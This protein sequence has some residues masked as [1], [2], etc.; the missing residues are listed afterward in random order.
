MQPVKVLVVMG[1]SG[2]GKTTIGRALA[3]RTGWTFHD[4]D[5][6]HGAD[7]LAKMRAG[8]P[9]TDHDRIPW[10]ETMRR[11]VVEPSLATGKPSIL[12]CSALKAAYLERLGASDTRVRVVCLVGDRGLI[13]GRMEQR[14]GHFMGAGM[15]ESQL[16]TLEVPDDAVVVD[17]T[18]PPQVIVDDIIRRIGLPQIR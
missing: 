2:S 10:L 3:G 15:L 8:V 5:D 6:Y 9:L 1:V 7:N 11:E 4:A 12:A 16:R 18:D 14:G 17:V 13:H